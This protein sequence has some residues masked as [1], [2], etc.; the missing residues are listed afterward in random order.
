M[1]RLGH[2]ENTR[3]ELSETQ[4]GQQKRASKKALDL[5]GRVEVARFEPLITRF[6]KHL[7]TPNAA[8][9]CSMIKNFDIIA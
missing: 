5:N 7:F 3:F 9:I 4:S 1:N 2:S 6:I 8:K